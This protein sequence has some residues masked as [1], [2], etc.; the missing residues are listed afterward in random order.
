MALTSDFLDASGVCLSEMTR[1]AF[2]LL[3][4]ACGAM[5]GCSLLAGPQT[6]LNVAVD[7][8][9]IGSSGSIDVAY[10]VANPGSR[11]DSIAACG[12]RP[13]PSIEQWDGHRWEAFGG[14]GCPANL[15]SL[16]LVL[17]VG[18]SVSDTI[19]IYP[20]GPGTYRV[21]LAYDRDWAP[22]VTSDAFTL[23]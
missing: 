8:A 4:L 1:F 23:Q 21:V 3:V 15:L 2:L 19:S 14:R 12:D 13:A 9:A 6:P 5:G 7:R 16:P 22:R 10:T 18:E 11:A 17:H 20:G